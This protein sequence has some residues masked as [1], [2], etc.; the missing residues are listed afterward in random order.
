MATVTM[1]AGLCSAT[2]VEQKWPPSCVVWVWVVRVGGSIRD[3]DDDDDDDDDGGGGGDA[4][5]W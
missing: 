2:G 4:R 5:W 1:V 3:D